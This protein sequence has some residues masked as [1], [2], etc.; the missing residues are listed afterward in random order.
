M[1]AANWKKATTKVRL[2]NNA[3]QGFSEVPHGIDSGTFFSPEIPAEVRA[4]VPLMHGIDDAEVGKF[5]ELAL[6]ALKRGGA[7]DDEDFASLTA[8]KEE[9]LD[10][11]G[12]IFTGVYCMIETAVRN[13]C[14]ASVVDKDLKE[15]NLPVRAVDMIVRKLKLERI[16]LEDRSST[17]PRFPRLEQLHWRIDVAISSSSLLRV[18]RPS[19]L[20]QMTL[21][22]GRMKTFDVSIEQF[23]QLRYNVAKVLRDMQELERHP[24]M[25][26]AFDADKKVFDE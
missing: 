1:A 25:R 20:L 9:N 10:K 18:F 19:I 17:N 26:I 2:I 11:Y 21:S 7:I 4:A 5:V 8:T 16:A 24:I 12:T 6:S 22:D 15:M 13:R 3:A 14:K 23:H